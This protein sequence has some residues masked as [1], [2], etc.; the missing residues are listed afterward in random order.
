MV[1][2]IKAPAHLDLSGMRR[3]LVWPLRA[4]KQLWES[5]RLNRSSLQLTIVVI[6]AAYLLIAVSNGIDWVSRAPQD[7]AVDIIA[8]ELLY[9]TSAS[10]TNIA[11]CLIYLKLRDRL[12]TV[13]QVIVVPLL[14]FTGGAVWITI[15][16]FAIMIVGMPLWI[17]VPFSWVSVL[18]QGGIAS[19]TTLF[20]VS[21]VA[22]GVD[23]WRQAALERENA[24]EAKALAHQA[25]LRMLRYQLNPHFLFNALNA[26]RGLILEDPQRSR[27]M[28]TELSDFL[29]YSL[30]DRMGEGTV[31]DELDAIENYLA[32]QRTR[33]ERQ[34]DAEMQIDPAALAIPLPSFLIH[35]LV[36][37]AVKHGMK[38]ATRPLRLRIEIAL[39]DNVLSI[40]VANTGHLAHGRDDSKENTRIGLKNITDRLELAF[41]DR[42]RFHLRQEKEWVIAEI[43]IRLAT[44]GAQA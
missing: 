13:G 9:N 5:A 2:T 16:H 33:F 32:I 20:L 27:R 17:G 7:Q 30:A 41:P 12:H 6:A 35:P 19:G 44:A 14:C 29:R 42:H 10:I 38:A 23:S 11:I 1:E 34:L 18:F 22:F 21:C 43:E 36:E 4:A 8:W 37:N 26:I 39:R 31:R 28:V 3:G 15:A 25:Q 40:T 24:R